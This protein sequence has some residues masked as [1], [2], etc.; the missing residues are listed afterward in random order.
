MAIEATQ[1]GPEG[2]I[3]QDLIAG[4]ITALVLLPQAVAF[5]QL[6]GLP[7]QF[8]LAASMLPPIV[9]A[10]LGSSRVLAVGPVSV[11][12]LMVASALAG[13]PEADRPAAALTLALEVGLILLACGFLRLGMLVNFVSQPVLS[14]FTTGA[15]LMIIVSQLPSLLG[16][17]TLGGPTPASGP[18][19]FGALLLT[20]M[21]AVKPGSALLARHLGGPPLLHQMLP[22][23]APIVIAG[24]A[25]AWLLVRGLGPEAGYRVVGPI[26]QVL[27]LPT[28]AAFRAETWASLLP[29]AAL[30]ALIG[31]VESVAI[32]KSMATASGE[33]ID[34]DRELLALGSANVVGGFTGA[35]PVAG[36]FSRTVVNAAAGAR[37]QLASVVT[38]L[39]L[40]VAGAGFANLLS[41]V[42]K[43]ALAAIIITAVV[44]LLHF[45]SLLTLWRYDYRDGAAAGA[46]LLGTMLLGVDSGVALGI[47]LTILLAVWR[48]SRPHI[49]VIGRLP[50]SQVFRN[51][52]RHAVQTWPHLLLVRPD[53][54]LTFANTDYV[55]GFIDAALGKHSTVRSV[56]LVCSAV[57]HIDASAVEGLQ[58]L[59]GDLERRGV[60]LVLTEVKGP[61]MDRLA[62]SPEL[63]RAHIEFIADLS[64]TIERLAA[65]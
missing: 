52:E 62:R 23:L 17:A 4:S 54:S 48:S 47:V 55:R 43:A 39:W 41:H 57:N 65:P 9:Y 30:I 50:G 34:A 19:L 5:A 37:S 20:A 18:L 8:G 28:L 56:V 16:L 13:L 29:S 35:M 61:V 38:A 24:I 25:T 58:S 27:P 53:E 64:E 40:C 46:T 63:Q 42:P 1:A 59:A 2:G 60:R 6:A 22:R 49:A 7:T 21:V 12:A 36:G 15:A 26:A 10:L 31:Y 32:A 45:G 3:G 11:A 44:P 14:G 33:R 51:V